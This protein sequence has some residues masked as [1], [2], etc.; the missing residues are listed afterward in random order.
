MSIL[1][2]I[3]EYKTKKEEIIKLFKETFFQELF[4]KYENLHF[5]PILSYTPYFNDG[6]PCERYTSFYLKY[7]NEG[8]Q[9]LAN[10]FDDSQVLDLIIKPKELF[11]LEAEEG[12][13]EYDADTLLE[14][15]S[16]ETFDSETL[17]THTINNKLT[18][19]EIAEI[20]QTL[21]SVVEFIEEILDD[22]SINLVKRQG[23]SVVIFDAEY[24]HD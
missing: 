5:I 9:Y 11:A 16:E 21:E 7:L 23:N 2:A 22:H 13:E 15:L 4:D 10:N 20:E 8:M 18:K 19:D 1:K 6:D 3:E 12:E 17:L 14:Y 24:E